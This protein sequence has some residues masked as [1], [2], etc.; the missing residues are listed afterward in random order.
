MLRYVS[1]K[2]CA[3]KK[4]AQR[5]LQGAWMPHIGSMACS[6]VDTKD[7]LLDFKKKERPHTDW[8]IPT[9]LWHRCQVLRA[10]RLEFTKL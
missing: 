3:L 10:E 5:M 2:K 9:I 1:K 7:H 4:N 8:Q 6:E